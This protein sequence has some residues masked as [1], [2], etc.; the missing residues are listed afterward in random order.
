MMAPSTKTKRLNRRGEAWMIIGTV[1]LMILALALLART[2]S[3]SDERGKALASGMLDR[4][5]TIQKQRQRAV[6]NTYAWKIDEEAQRIRQMWPSADSVLMYRWLPVLQVQHTIQAIVLAD[7]RGNEWSLDHAD[8]SWIYTVT[9]RTRGEVSTQVRSWKINELSIPP[10]RLSEAGPDPRSA[11]WF[12]Q[13]VGNQKGQPTWMEGE[14]AETGKYLHLSQVVRPQASPANL[15]VISFKL[16]IK[17]LLA[18]DEEWDANIPGMIFN[19]KLQPMVPSDSGLRGGLWDEAVRAYRASQSLSTFKFSWD[20]HNWQGQ[21]VPMYLNGIT[22][23]TGS[24]VDLEG[25]GQWSGERRLSLWI[26]LT[27]LLLLSLLLTLIFMQ[28]RSTERQVKRQERRSSQ[29]AR[30]LARAI[31]EREVLDREV[32]HRV[33]N[34]LQV[35][36]SLL[37]LQAQRIPDE[38]VRKEFMRGKRRIDSMALVHHKLYRQ[39]DLSSVDLGVFID[40]VTKAMAAM[41]DP[42]SRTVGHSV[43]TAGI[44]GDADTSIQLGMILCELLA[45][46]FQHAFPTPIG[47]HIHITVRDRGDGSYLLTVKDNG[48]GFTDD[49]IKEQHLGLEVVDALAGQLDG[50]YSVT[51]NDGTQVDVIFH[52]GEQL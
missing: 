29:Q 51:I 26:I 17:P 31:E 27:L 19:A 13:A 39:T 35:V 7:D 30:H 52:M 37:N 22:F 9:K 23:H 28:N 33:K 36:S 12:G 1:C 24:A 41:F 14:G 34:N 6:F 5:L 45:N 32:H 38:G 47:G 50:S 48:Q 10:P 25:V 42:D 16:A 15:M 40:D 21:I 18:V 4:A 49:A 8:G 2:I 46:C 3:K 43:D 44:K 11:A 20:G